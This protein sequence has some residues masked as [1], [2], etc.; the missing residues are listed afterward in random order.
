MQNIVVRGDLIVACSWD[1]TASVWDTTSFALLATLWLNS[2]VLCAA[3]T[4]EHIIVGCLNGILNLYR[5]SDGF[6]LEYV[7]NVGIEV[8]A[9][10]LLDDD[11]F[12]VGGEDGCLLFFSLSTKSIVSKI[13]DKGSVWSIAVLDDGRLALGD[14]NGHCAI[15]KPPESVMKLIPCRAAT[16]VPRKPPLRPAQTLEKRG[17][18]GVSNDTV[19]PLKKRYCWQ[20]AKHS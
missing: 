4:D 14:D 18:T 11:L 1:C 8:Y 13:K 6:P 16:A 12:A 15:T 2:A 20:T 9:I 7:I 17:G 3:V 19:L 10:A 5:K